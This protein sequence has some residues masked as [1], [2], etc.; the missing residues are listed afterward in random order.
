MPAMR[1][2]KILVKQ[3]A[4]EHVLPLPPVA[5]DA[6][7]AT[8]S[9]LNT[10]ATPDVL[11]LYSLMGGMENMTNDYWRHWSM[12]EILSENREASEFGVLFAD[13]L[14]SS[15]CYRV[16]ARPDNTSAVYVDHFNGGKPCLVANSLEEFFDQYLRSAGEAL[17]GHAG[18]KNDA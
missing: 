14:I 2:L 8:F 15:W 11:H 17:H 3:W 18:A 6:V 9:R 1:S 5:A 7:R 13:Y 12:D 10:V 4:A 16:K